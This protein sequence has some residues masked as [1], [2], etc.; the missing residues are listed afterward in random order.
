MCN[1]DAVRGS[2]SVASFVVDPLV[3]LVAGS[4]ARQPEGDDDGK[5]RAISMSSGRFSVR[6]NSQMG[7][8]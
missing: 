3:S 7:F 2:P 8:V 6:G 4:L 5:T 1:L